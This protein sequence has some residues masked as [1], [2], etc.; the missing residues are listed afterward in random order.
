LRNHLRWPYSTERR[1]KAAERRRENLDEPYIYDELITHIYDRFT[2][3]PIFTRAVRPA[4]PNS[5]SWQYYVQLWRGLPETKDEFDK[6]LSEMD[7]LMALR[8]DPDTI[9]RIGVVKT[10][11]YLIESFNAHAE[12]YSSKPYKD[13]IALLDTIKQ[14]A[15]EECVALWS[16]RGD[17]VKRLVVP[18]ADARLK[19]AMESGRDKVRAAERARLKTP[20]RTKPD[21]APTHKAAKKTKPGQSLSPKSRRV[22]GERLK[23]TRMDL[24]WTQ[25]KLAEVTR[26]DLRTIQRGESSGRWLLSRFDEVAQRLTATGKIDIQAK[27]LMAE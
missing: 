4:V 1:Q 6:F 14:W 12:A 7:P 21:A 18:K 16:G 8:D 27:D 9:D 17:W 20:A 24:G 26:Q 3:T 15:I 2:G 23:K 22:N 13:F 11:K 25:E 19:L 10:A 5:T